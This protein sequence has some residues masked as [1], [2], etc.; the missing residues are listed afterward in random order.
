MFHDVLINKEF[1]NNILNMTRH[2]EQNETFSSI[3]KWLNDNLKDEN[4]IKA[5]SGHVSKV[6]KDK[7]IYIW[8]MQSD[9]YLE[10]SHFISINS[11]D[12]KFI[13]II[14]EI[15]YDLVYLGTAGTRKNR[16][17]NLNE[18][19]KWHICQ[20]HN[21][22]AI[23]HGTISTLR[24]GI[25]ALLADDLIGTNTETC[26]N[27]FIRSNMVVYW[28]SYADFEEYIDNDEKM[29]ISILKPLLNIKNN[30]NARG[31]ANNNPS[32]F[33]KQRRCLVMKSTRAKLPCKGEDEKTI[34]EK[35]IPSNEAIS[36]QDQIYSDYEKG[37][38]EY[39]V[40]RDQDI[41]RITRGINGLPNGYSKIEIWDSSNSNL[42]FEKWHRVTGRNPCGQNIY[43]YFANTSSG[44][45]PRR[46][47]V[48]QDWMNE[49]NIDEIT[50]KVSRIN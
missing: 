19:L 28:I 12:L 20:T 40:S 10:L 17:S 47:I 23:C 32:K 41:A 25:C 11:L 27:D 50:V 43:T 22:S 5:C 42:K 48:I 39:F 34:K 14:N 46:S 13:R 15:Q 16:G 1:K 35:N 26:V 36:Y 8:F 9:A 2:L 33:Y 44:D 21:N 30:P 18:R 37:C 4:S 38:I 49:K 7:G 3:D 31:N 6:P 29:L 45:G 24:A